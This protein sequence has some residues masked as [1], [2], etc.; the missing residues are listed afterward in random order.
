M[1]VLSYFTNNGR[2]PALAE[3]LDASCEK[4][5]VE[6]RI[7]QMEDWGEWLTNNNL[8]PRFILEQ[9]IDVRGPVLWMDIDTEFVG[10]PHR[11]IS[12][13]ESWRGMCDFGIY[14]WHADRANVNNVPYDEKRLLGSGGVIY[15]DYTAPAIEILLRWIAAL[16]ANPQGVDDQVLDTVF[17]SH[18][19]P[20]VRPTWF[21]KRM[22][23]MI[24]LFGEANADT[25]IRHDFVNRKHY[26]H[27]EPIHA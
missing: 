25:I 11:F 2:Y 6:R 23:H 8:K 18:N 21:Q 20:P 17:N 22:N 24:G 7:V 9:L 13:W 3:R 19:R 14:N 10:D 4:F 12:A 5:L 27:T 1:T 26:E 16:N 15:F